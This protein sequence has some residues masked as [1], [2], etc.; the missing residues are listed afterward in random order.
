MLRMLRQVVPLIK[1]GEMIRGWWVGG[2]RL[3][4]QRKLSA[5]LIIKLITS[6]PAAPNHP[7][8]SQQETKNI[9]SFIPSLGTIIHSKSFFSITPLK[10]CKILWQYFYK[11]ETFKICLL[12][13]PNNC[14]S[15][16]LNTLFGYIFIVPHWVY[17]ILIFLKYIVTIKVLEILSMKIKFFRKTPNEKPISPQI[18]K[19]NNFLKTVKI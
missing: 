17:Y 11:L 5:T 13:N 8:K 10:C 6:A 3:Q 16:H 12:P 9:R 4:M 18:Y 15:K 7:H 19:K 14:I 1:V 2:W